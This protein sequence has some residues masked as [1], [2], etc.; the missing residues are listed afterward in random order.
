[1]AFSCVQ[2]KSASGSGTTLAITFNSDTTSGN[3]IGVGAAVFANATLACADNKSNTYPGS[4]GRQSVLYGTSSRCSIFDA[5]NITGGASHQV[6]ATAGS[7]GTIA[8]AIAE[9]SGVKTTTPWQVGTIQNSL[10]TTSPTSGNTGTTT[11]TDEL[12][13]GVIYCPPSTVN[14]TAAGGTA[15]SGAVGSS[16]V[17]RQEIDTA[18]G[19]TLSI[20]DKLSGA[21]GATSTAWTSSTSQDH[22]VG[23]EA[24][25]NAAAGDTLMA[26]ICF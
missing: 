2:S 12:V 21:V 19:E 13:F 16:L 17:E 9:Y 4:N 5:A 11:E 15:S 8:M 3:F 1:M 22:S 24:Y 23:C 18:G 10:A 20:G 25:L 7:S 26:A 6:T 14:Y